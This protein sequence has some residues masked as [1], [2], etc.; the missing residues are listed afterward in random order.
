MWGSFGDIVFKLAKTPG[1]ISI[2]EKAKFAKIEIFGKKT[3]LHFTGF[4]ENKIDL[5]I[6]L[7]ISFCNPK[8]EIE[9]LEKLKEEAK[10][11]KLIIGDENLGNFVIEEMKTDILKTS[12]KGQ[13]LSAQIEIKLAEG[14]I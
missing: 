6:F 7:N 4:E 11:Q 9:K 2:T 3:K 10:A 13:I 1:N 5:S 8:E 14:E 12:P